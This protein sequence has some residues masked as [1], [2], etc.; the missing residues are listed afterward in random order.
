MNRRIRDPYVRW[1]GRSEGVTPPPTRWLNL[2]CYH[3]AT[4]CFI[5]VTKKG[6]SEFHGLLI[7]N[8][9]HEVTIN[10]HGNL[11]RTVT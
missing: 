9:L 4:I 2:I 10:V 11:D 3:F 5:L 1:C 8:W 7:I 6:S